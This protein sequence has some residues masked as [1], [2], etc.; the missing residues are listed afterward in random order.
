MWHLLRIQLH[1]WLFLD[2]SLLILLKFQISDL[3]FKCLLLQ[4]WSKSM[5]WI[6]ICKKKGRRE[7]RS[8]N[9]QIMGKFTFWACCCSDRVYWSA[10]S[11]NLCFSL[12]WRE[13]NYNRKRSN[14]FVSRQNY[15]EIQLNFH[16][17]YIFV[18][19]TLLLH[20]CVNIM[21]LAHFRW[22]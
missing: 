13:L 15:T 14:I 1:L 12:E 9:H 2:Q 19:L 4:L 20:K 3:K 22:M 6:Q 17:Q 8:G 16:P 5:K 18:R 11:F 7:K 10:S 21:V